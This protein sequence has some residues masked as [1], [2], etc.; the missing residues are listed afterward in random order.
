[1]SHPASVLHHPT[2]A[3][4][5]PPRQTDATIHPIH[6]LTSPR[7]TTP[8]HPGVPGSPAAN[9][10]RA[11]DL[12]AIFRPAAASTWV[13]TAA[14]DSGPVG[15]TAISVVSV[16]LNPALVSFNIAKNS[17]SLVTLARSGTLALHLLGENQHQLA[18]RFSA[19]R[20]LRFA[21]DETWGFDDDGLPRLHHV[22]ARLSAELVDLVDAGD[23]FV[24]IARVGAAEAEA[25][26]P[27][28]H[29]N[30]TYVATGDP[31]IPVVNDR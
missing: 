29:R 14:G 16:S 31:S 23:S 4:P 21:V 3:P 27:L 13:I 20:A 28:V 24:A 1:M 9:P 10:A 25:A 8:P 5:E 7:A 17:S 22:A 15:F 6:A 2:L 12:R 18:E 19:D 30:G 26:A 11:V